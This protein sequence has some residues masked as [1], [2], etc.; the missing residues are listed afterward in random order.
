MNGSG[1][2]PEEEVALNLKVEPLS[3]QDLDAELTHYESEFGMTSA[4]FAS[5]HARGEA[6]EILEE[7]ALEWL[8]ALEAWKLVSDADRPP[9]D[10]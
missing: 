2:S 9:L 4:G 1:A 7:T 8:M 3:V 5:A 10:R 6:I